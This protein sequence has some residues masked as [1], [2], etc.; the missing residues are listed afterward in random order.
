M[1]DYLSFLRQ[2]A[3]L[4]DEAWQIFSQKFKEKK[5]SKGEMTKGA[6]SPKDPKYCSDHP[7]ALIVFTNFIHFSMV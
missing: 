7:G 5:V 2:V 1:I 3:P 6:G 4:S